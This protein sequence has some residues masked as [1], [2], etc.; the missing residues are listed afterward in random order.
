MHTDSSFAGPGEPVGRAD[1]GVDEDAKRAVA[2]ARNGRT[3]MRGRTVA[4][5][6]VLALA[7]PFLGWAA[8]VDRTWLVRYWSVDE[9]SASAAAAWRL[10]PLLFGL[11]LAFIVRPRVGRWVDALGVREAARSF[12]RIALAVVF[13]LAASESL[14]RAVDH[15]KKH[16]FKGSCDNEMGEPDARIGWLWRANFEHTVMQGGRAIHFAFDAHHDRVSRPGVEEDPDRPTVLLVGDS[17]VAG[18]GLEWRESL[19]GLLEEALRIQVVDLGV[20]GYGSDQAFL[21]LVDAIPRFR[22]LV[23]V[24]T[25]FRPDMVERLAWSDRPQL[26]FE[27]DVPAVSPRT[28]GFLGDLRV[29]RVIADLLPYRDEGSIQL[30]GH[31]FRE[32]ARLSAARGA[33]AVFLTP[34]LARS[35]PPSDGYLVRELLTAEGLETVN[36]DWQ[37]QPLLGDNH[38]NPAS[39]RR[40]AAALI[41]ALAA[42]RR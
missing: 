27:S 14:L 5:L 31:I 25:L 28:P 38:P 18:H 24:V 10:G 20:D 34:T 23:A 32:T 19:A 15:P 9:R 29:V 37:Y 13:A 36:P 16:D 39:T 41:E 26:S 8:W 4:E 21:R 22:H 11:V 12:G 1:A 40:L 17:F 7:A 42:P 3:L 30:G 2:S 6:A 35:W 33:R